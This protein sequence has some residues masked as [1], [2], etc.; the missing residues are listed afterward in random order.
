MTSEEDKTWVPVPLDEIIRQGLQEELEVAIDE[1]RSL[2]SAGI[3]ETGPKWTNLWYQYELSW[4]DQEKHLVDIPSRFGD[5]FVETA[6]VTPEGFDMLSSLSK[7]F[8]KED[9]RIPPPLGGFMVRLLDGEVVRPKPIGS[10]PKA[11][12]WVRNMMIHHTAHT[13]GSRYGFEKYTRNAATE[14]AAVSD[15][16]YHAVRSHY[17]ENLDFGTVQNTLNNSRVRD[18]FGNIRHLYFMA[19][20]DN[21]D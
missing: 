13:L 20:L 16:V 19:L 7:A 17:E 18:A 15:L 14:T 2:P 1:I 12:I 6:R 3:F 8:L 21:L 10:P 5:E 11:D 9:R 4:L